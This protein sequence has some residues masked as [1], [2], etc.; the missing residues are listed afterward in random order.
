MGE[1][2]ES[3]KKL[4]SNVA[5][6]VKKVLGKSN[7]TGN[8]A[9]SAA[10]VPDEIV[11]QRVKLK[12]YI[13]QDCPQ[14]F[15]E[16]LIDIITAND[17]N[18]ARTK[19]INFVNKNVRS[20]TNKRHVEELVITLSLIS[21]YFRKNSSQ[22]TTETPVKFK[23]A[24]TNL[25]S[26]IR[27]WLNTDQACEISNKTKS[28]KNI[29]K[30]FEKAK[31][32]T[33]TDWTQLQELISKISATGEDLADYQ[34]KPLKM[35]L[36]EPNLFIEREANRILTD[37]NL[38]TLED[39]KKAFADF[40][41]KAR[42]KIGVSEE[43]DR[44]NKEIQ[45]NTAFNWTCFYTDY[46]FGGIVGRARDALCKIWKKATKLWAKE[47][48]K[49]KKI[50]QIRIVGDVMR[51][52]KYV[53]SEDGTE[54]IL[55]PPLEGSQATLGYIVNHLRKIADSSVAERFYPGETDIF[56][57]NDTYKITDCTT[58]QLRTLK[59]AYDNH[60]VSTWG[61]FLKE[62]VGFVHAL[63][64]HGNVSNDWLKYDE[65]IKMNE[66]DWTKLLQKLDQKEEE[67]RNKRQIDNKDLHIND[68]QK[69]EELSRHAPP[70]TIAPENIA[71]THKYTGV[72]LWAKGY[73]V[74]KFLGAGGFG[75]AW[76][77]ESNDD[78]SGYIVMKVLSG[79]ANLTQDAN[80]SAT[81]EEIQSVKTLNEI[82]AKDTTGRAKRYLLK[83]DVADQTEKGVGSLVKSALAEGDLL[84][85]TWNKYIEDSKPGQKKPLKLSGVLRRA[86]QALK[87]VKALHDAG[88]SH[89]DIKP[90][91]F[92]R[93]QNW[94][95]KKAKEDTVNKIIDITERDAS[96]E[97]K[98]KEIN[99]IN[100]TNKSLKKIK[101][102][103][104]S[105]EDPDTKIKHISEFI[106]DKKS[107]KHSLNLSD[108]GTLTELHL[109]TNP[110]W[111]VWC[112]ISSNGYLCPNDLNHVNRDNDGNMYAPSECI[113]K[114]DVYALGVTLMH[115][116]V[117]RLNWNVVGTVDWLQKNAVSASDAKDIIERYGTNSSDKIVRYLQLIQKMVN[118]NWKTRISLDDALEEI[119]TIK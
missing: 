27:I 18:D 6:K 84:H 22:N 78:T 76:A 42:R 117:A 7:D 81:L 16:S 37:E 63:D 25:S 91:N 1:K 12:K 15:K 118:V 19:I 23:N 68:T 108:F 41:D 43:L 58:E 21:L 101:D 50:T 35:S 59:N 55:Y 83:M 34:N 8:T 60:C 80:T 14:K 112:A 9:D 2:L 94:A 73:K 3:F 119:Q 110:A 106:K 30:I 29:S 26:K 102:I 82:L 28:S 96:N 10:I 103:V 88:Y 56:P 105:K 77:C 36:D 79:N 93:V 40:I 44:L 107:H 66:Q 111:G 70:E 95:G 86:K 115:F 4:G 51:S 52:V 69:L 64:E 98:V 72:Y 54:L 89:N 46:T 57:N 90:E 39:L 31:K 92:L 48:L 20:L 11:V 47:Y 104:E 97:D 74:K 109:N 13:Q 17:I 53:V 75:A 32:L 38:E 113:A 45:T 61:E 114:R 67:E 33:N 87:S 62:E 100:I 65:V 99:S 5:A 71:T 116:L 24:R 85:I 49:D